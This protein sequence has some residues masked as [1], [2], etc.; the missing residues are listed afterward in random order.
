MVAISATNSAT[1]SVQQ[2]L[3]Q[4]RLQQA[5]RE[6]DQAEAN[7]QNLRQQADSA[8]LQ[9]QKSQSR[10]REE[11]ARSQQSGSTYES[12]IKGSKSEVPSKTQEFLVGLYD[13]TREQRAANGNA[14]KT[15][16]NASSVLNMQG[17][18]TGRIVNLSA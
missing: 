7:A 3:N 1:P 14:L 5:R 6:A 16:T 15:D 12:P 18:T 11:T 2:S 10:V 4:T 8:E 13:A 9:A 17:Q